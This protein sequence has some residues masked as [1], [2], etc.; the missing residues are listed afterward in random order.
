MNESSV[1][2]NVVR[3]KKLC[4]NGKLDM[5]NPQYRGNVYGRQLSPSKLNDRDILL[6]GNHLEIVTYYTSIHCPH[7]HID[8]LN[9]C[10]STLLWDS[11]AKLSWVSCAQVITE[12]RVSWNTPRLCSAECNSSYF[13]NIF[14]IYMT[15]LNVRVQCSNQFFC[16]YFLHTKIT[17]ACGYITHI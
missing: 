15:F 14:P 12:T 5:N 16:G 11:S 9:K 1:D 17:G 8:D 7:S 4:Q 13:E 6:R 10:W 2:S 3:L